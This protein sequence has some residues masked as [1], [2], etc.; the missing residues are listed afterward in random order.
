MQGLS[1]LIEQ[2]PEAENLEE[3]R[4]R[5]L[6]LVSKIISGDQGIVALVSHRVINQVLICA[7]L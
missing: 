5:A 3:V 7:L 2:H 6:N 4:K 1:E